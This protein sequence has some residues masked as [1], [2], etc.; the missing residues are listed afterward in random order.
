[1]NLLENPLMK[2]IAFPA[3]P[4]L[5]HTLRID[6][7]VGGVSHQIVTVELYQAQQQSFYYMKDHI[8]PHLLMKSK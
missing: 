8:F 4:L 6:K 1:M 3:R 5:Q 7:G 2:N